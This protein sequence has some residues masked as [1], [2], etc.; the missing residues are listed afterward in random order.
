MARDQADQLIEQQYPQQFAAQVQALGYGNSA[1]L[2]D[3]DYRHVANE[4]LRSHL[5][6]LHAAAVAA[7]GGGI[8]PSVAP[9]FAARLAQTGASQKEVREFAAAHLYPDLSPD[10]AVKR[11]QRDL[12]RASGSTVA[13]PREPLFD[14]PF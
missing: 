8:D 6:D 4:V 10:A 11:Y 5:G 14:R 13:E 1:E 3:E 2:V 12:A 7:D 9:A